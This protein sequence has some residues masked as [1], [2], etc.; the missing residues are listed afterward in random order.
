MG[1]MALALRPRQWIKNVLVFAG[2]L[3]TLGQGHPLTDYAK[4]VAA[5]VVFCLLSGCGYLVND[6][7]D[8][9]KDRLHPHKRLRPLAL[10]AVSPRTA[11][12]FVSVVLPV[13]LLAA[14]VV[15]PGLFAVGALYFAVTTAYTLH[16]KNIVVVDVMVVASGFVLRAIAGSVTVG[17]DPSGWL[18]LCTGLLALFVALNKRRGEIV[19]LGDASPTRPI[20]S[21]YSVALLDQMITITASCCIIAYSLYTFFSETGRHRPYLMATIPFVLYG[22][23]RYLYLANRHNQGEAPE[24]VLAGDGPL[25]INLLLWTVTAA[26]ALLIRAR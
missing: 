5:F 14:Y 24:L 20:L 15:S 2:L 3:F 6:L 7:R 22:I 21:E 26:A 25:R 10:G 17:V 23:F 19:A 11:V 13:T 9:A 4:A 18:L 1:A 12:W 8:L 16:L